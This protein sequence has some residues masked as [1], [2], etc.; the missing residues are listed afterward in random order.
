[1]QNDFAQK[2]IFWRVNF[3]PKNLYLR[4]KIGNYHGGV[5][6][7]PSHQFLDSGAFNIDLRG[8]R[9]WYS[10]EFIYSLGD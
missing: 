1:M 5:D 10:S 8:P 7:T 4:N 9:F 2:S 6:S 3:K